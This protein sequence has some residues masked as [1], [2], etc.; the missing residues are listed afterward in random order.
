MAHS[1]EEDEPFVTISSLSKVAPQGWTMY[2]HPRGSMYFRH[3]NYG[4]VVDEDIH[5]Q[6]NLDKVVDFCTQHYRMDLPDYMEAHMAYGVD[7]SVCLYVN[8]KQCVAGYTLDNLW[9][10]A[11]KELSVDGRE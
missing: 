9:G 2:T 4:V 10:G 6:A 7:A 3:N 5:I 11:V 8:H 1:Y